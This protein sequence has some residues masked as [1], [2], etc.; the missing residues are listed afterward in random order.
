[1]NGQQAN[2]AGVFFTLYID[3]TFAEVNRKGFTAVLQTTKQFY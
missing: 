1:M 2:L 3:I